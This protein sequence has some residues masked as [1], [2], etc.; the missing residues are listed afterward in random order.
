MAKRAK[1]QETEK[2]EPTEPLASLRLPC[3]PEVELSKAL[4][5]EPEVL[6]RLAHRT[7]DLVADHGH[8][9]WLAASIGDYLNLMVGDVVLEYINELIREARNPDKE[10]PRG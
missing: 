2:R 4:Q 5:Q 9:A 10:V 8:Y 3:A 7:A 1:S 6:R